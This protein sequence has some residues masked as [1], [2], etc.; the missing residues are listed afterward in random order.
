[1]HK[2]LGVKAPE[3]PTKTWG[4]TQWRGRA[5]CKGVLPGA[6]RLVRMQ[7]MNGR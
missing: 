5:W 2:E 6:L 3:K 1:M 7:C 4:L